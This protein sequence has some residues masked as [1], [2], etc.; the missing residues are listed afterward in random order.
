MSIVIFGDSFT[1]PEGFASTNRVYGYAK[2]LREN[3]VNV[4]VVCFRNDYR[5]VSD[6]EVNQI[7]YYHPFGQAVRSKSF[8]RRRFLKFKKY[9]RTVA[10]LKEIDR[11]DKISEMLVYTMLFSTH[12]FAWY[13]SRIYRFK[14]LKECSEH[15]LGQY[16]RN[17][18]K[19]TE[20]WLKMKTEMYLSDSIFCISRYLIDFYVNQGFPDKRLFLVPSTVDPSRFS[21]G[22]EPP[23]TFKYI[24]YFGGL[25]FTRDNV[26]ALIRAFAIIHNNF[27]DLKLV[28]G[29]FYTENEKYQFD[30]LVSDL[31]ISS[32]VIVLN[33]LKRDEIIRFIV[34]S[35]ILVMVRSRD[36]ESKASF[37][38]KLTEYMATGKPVITVNVGEISDY[39]VDN[40]N[41][42]I[43]EAGNHKELAQK[44]SFVI[45]NY[46]F[47]LKVAEK[48]KE[49]TYTTFNYSIQAKRVVEFLREL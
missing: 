10:L 18:F 19:K 47:A 42:F 43:V 14:I 34:H 22:G 24:G 28:F 7:P 2:G 32:S 20:G 37:P 1:F 40:V 21:Q 11:E 12:L 5:E 4:R 16:Q 26:D 30:Q 39:L 6:S 45:G 44:I 9:F 46:D 41:S 48:G 27:P 15:P 49:L 3:G 33:S 25:T 36:L 23:Y 38:S 17:F 29:G 31:N 35:H 13:L 8:I